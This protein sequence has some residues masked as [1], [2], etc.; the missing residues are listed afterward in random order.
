MLAVF[1]LLPVP[2]LDGSRL[3]DV[4]LPPRIYRQVLRYEWIGMLVVVLLLLL[5]VLNGPL[6]FLT[7]AMLQ[8]L[9]FLTSFMEL[10]FFLLRRVFYG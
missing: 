8:S 7:N 2:P 1:N 3:L 6:D 5:G 4:L 10:L 9:N